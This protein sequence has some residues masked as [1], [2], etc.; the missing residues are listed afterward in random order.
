VTPPPTPVVPPAPR[1]LPLGSTISL[2]GSLFARLRERKQELMD[3]GQITV[4]P[5]V[6]VSNGHLSAAAAQAL[7]RQAEEASDAQP[8]DPA[9]RLQLATLYSETGQPDDA[10]LCYRL[11]LRGEPD[12]LADLAAPIEQ[13]AAS[14]PHE[15]RVLRLLGDLYLRQGRYTQAMAVF[16]SLMVAGASA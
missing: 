7:L 14:Y 3:L 4:R 12:M 2:A 16:Q 15:P 9:A 6:A 13:L 1:A 10:A 8:T 11:L 5:S